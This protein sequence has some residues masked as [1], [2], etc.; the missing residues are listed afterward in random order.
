M[1]RNWE[2][3][4]QAMISKQPLVDLS[5]DDLRKIYHPP[6]GVLSKREKRGLEEIDRR[7]GELNRV[8]SDSGRE[9]SEVRELAAALEN[10]RRSP[11]PKLNFFTTG[12]QVFDFLDNSIG[13]GDHEASN[14]TEDSGRLDTDPPDSMFWSGSRM[15]EDQN[16]YAGFGRDSVPDWSSYRWEYDEPKTSSGSNPGFEVRC[17]KWKAKVKLGETTSEPF[18]ARIFFALGYNADA[19]D[20]VEGLRVRYSRRLLREFNMR[21]PVNLKISIVGPPIISCNLQ[22]EFNPFDYIE[23]AIMRDGSSVSSDELKS[24]LLKD[25]DR[26]TP[27]ADPANFN[28]DFE[29]E[30]DCLVL[31]PVNFQLKN[32]SE[33]SVGRWDYGE[34]EHQD[35]RELRGAGLLAAWLGFFDCRFDNTS[36]RLCQ[37]TDG[38]DRLV[39]LFSDLGA[40]MGRSDWGFG[41]KSEDP[42][43]FPWEFTKPAIHRGPGQMTT[44]FRVVRFH[45]IEDNAAF[46]EMTEADARWMARRIG[47]LSIAQIRGALIA[48]GLDASA[49]T[50]YLAK[51]VS[52]RNRLMEDLELSTEFPPLESGVEGRDFEYDP[53]TN[54]LPQIM[55]NGKPIFARGGENV[56]HNGHLEPRLKQAEMQERFQKIRADII[57]SRINE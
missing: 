27:F 14:I 25:L 39:A 1:K 34:L 57:D 12:F 18:T 45:T 15:I 22:R 43:E 37:T 3:D 26:P 55:V 54:S 30:L 56:I 10:D 24:H 36:L 4:C 46:Q 23:S 53:Q 51:L 9:F 17:G 5:E 19:C 42:N 6:D 47:R 21:E 35:L 48:A 7:L 41:W 50:L 11:I 28:P 8:D 33:R 52:R 16:L 49:T 40:G 32:D 20:H 44:P 31:K 2:A 29:K 38:E 13:G